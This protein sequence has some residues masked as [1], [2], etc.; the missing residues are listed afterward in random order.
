VGGESRSD[1]KDHGKEHEQLAV[2]RETELVHQG[3]DDPPGENSEA[4]HE[5]DDQAEGLGQPRQ[6][7]HGVAA[8]VRVASR[9]AGVRREAADAQQRAHTL[10]VELLRLSQQ[11]EA[12]NS[13]SSQLAVRGLRYH[14]LQWGGPDLVTPAQPPLLMLHG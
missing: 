1:R 14:L 4:H 9:V 13:R 11:A 2:T 5:S 8:R 3:R 6:R 10:H 7:A 12:A